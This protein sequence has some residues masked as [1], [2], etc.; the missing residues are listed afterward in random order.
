MNQMVSI[1]GNLPY[2]Q[3]AQVFLKLADELKQP[4]VPEPPAPTV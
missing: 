3:V 4:D 1:L 2:V